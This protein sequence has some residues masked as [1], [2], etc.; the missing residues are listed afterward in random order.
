MGV[1][2]STPP[3]NIEVKCVIFGLI[4]YF[5]FVDHSLWGVPCHIREQNYKKK[6]YVISLNY[7]V[8]LGRIQSV[9]LNYSDP[10]LVECADTL[11][12]CIYVFV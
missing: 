4:C 11:P 12:L 8:V 10:F 6:K 5:I 1:Q 9:N 2:E 3:R 7:I